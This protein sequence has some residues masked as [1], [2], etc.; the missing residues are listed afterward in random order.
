MAPLRRLP[1]STSASSQMFGKVG[2]AKENPGSEAIAFN[3]HSQRA[4]EAPLESRMRDCWCPVPQERHT[5]PHRTPSASSA[6]PSRDRGRACR[7]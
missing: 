3:W 2:K 7:C 6:S 5:L 4:A 1:L